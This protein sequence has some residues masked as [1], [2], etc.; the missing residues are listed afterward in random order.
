[1]MSPV[2]Y[3]LLISVSPLQVERM[4]FHSGPKG[5]SQ[6]AS[7][8]EIIEGLLGSCLIPGNSKNLFSSEDINQ[9]YFFHKKPL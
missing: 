4:Y 1:M 8:V 3:L 6:S 5:S 9:L 2:T 7:L